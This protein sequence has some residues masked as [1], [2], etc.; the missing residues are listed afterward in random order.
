MNYN[1]IHEENLDI[2][3]K[4]RK[5]DILNELELEKNIELS[6][7]EIR[8]LMQI[9]S[10]FSLEKNFYELSYE[11]TTK[12]FKNF[13]SKFKSLYDFAYSIL[14][15]LGNFPNRE[16]LYKYGFEGFSSNFSALLEVMARENDNL[17]KINEDIFRLTDFQKNFYDYISNKEKFSISAPTSAGKS[18]V[19]QMSILSKFKNNKNQNIVFI[20]PTR[21]LIIEFSKK[22]RKLFKHYNLSDIEIRTLPIYKEDDNKNILYILTQ[23]RLNTLLEED[24]QIDILFI[25]EAQEIQSNRGVILQNTIEKA[26]VKFPNIHLYFASPL[27][28]NPEVFNNLFNFSNENS[29]IETFSPV[30]Q[31]ILFVSGIKSKTKKINLNLY[32]DENFIEIGQFNVDFKF[33]DNGKIIDFSLYITK[34]DEQTIIYSNYPAKAEKNALLLSEK[35]DNVNDSEI[36]DF[37]SYIKEDIHEDYSLIKCLKK[38]VAYHY[39]YMPSNVKIKIEE[40]AS[41]GKLKYICCTSTLLQG[42]N[43]P[44]KNIVV[45]KPKSGKYNEMKRSDFLNLIGRAGRLQKEFNGNI[46][47]IETK[48]WENEIYKGEKLQEIKPYYKEILLNDTDNILKFL[49]GEKF[50]KEEKNKSYETVFGKFFIDEIIDKKNSIAETKKIKKLKEESLKIKLL[51]SKDIYKKHYSIHPNALNRLYE[52]LKKQNNIQQFIPQKIFTT[53]SNL[54]NIIQMININILNK[55]DSSYKFINNIMRKWIHNKLLKDIIIEYHKYYK[56]DK[57]K[58][59]ITNSIKEV[60]EIIEKDIRFRYVLYISAYIDIL[61]IVLDE[62]GVKNDDIP[63]LPLYLES[64]SG[65]AT[66]INLISLGLSRNTS[67]RLYKLNILDECE[68]IKECYEKL[69]SLEI[70]EL[71]LPNI[72]KEEILSIL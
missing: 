59:K 41:K 61:K 72:L 40:L 70:D 29:D 50:N 44:V 37:I 26:I 13:S 48:D 47:C 1:K 5:I 19:F 18:F 51:L 63:N 25:D 64:G 45:Y 71:K 12:L 10:L 46:W 42:V 32:K 69:K 65:S 35:L 3:N 56:K 2:I 27:I 33:R 53:G 6:E 16:L 49:K 22:M 58:D 34:E 31:N 57:D 39:S 68:N 17:I 9:A 15:R 54:K 43:L 60:L 8:Q 66:V 11:I 21:A 4:L 36:N 38:G 24:I 7:T 20:V 62:K 30:G 23:E 14:S 55:N 67:I 52:S 28:K